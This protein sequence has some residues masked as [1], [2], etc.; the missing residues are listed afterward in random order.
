M[1]CNKGKSQQATFLFVFR[2][3]HTNHRVGEHVTIN[4]DMKPDFWPLSLCHCSDLLVHSVYLQLA[5]LEFHWSCKRK[6]VAIQG[7]HTKNI[8][9]W[10]AFKFPDDYKCMRAFNRCGNAPNPGKQSGTHKFDD[11]IAVPHMHT[12]DIWLL[13]SHIY[14]YI[15][16]IVEE[17]DYENMKHF[18]RKAMFLW[19]L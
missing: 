15:H 4:S 6:L 7:G 3:S 11:A 13:Y 9:T 16:M 8:H 2:L 12:L 17:L 19:V 10:S 18:Q 5:Y 14:I 1:S